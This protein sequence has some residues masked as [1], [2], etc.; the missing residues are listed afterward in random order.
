MLTKWSSSHVYETGVTIIVLLNCGLDLR[1]TISNVA[2]DIDK[3]VKLA[4]GSDSHL[5]TSTYI[6]QL[7]YQGVVALTCN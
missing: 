1:G 4:G 6:T 3:V 2:Y 5:K 7:F